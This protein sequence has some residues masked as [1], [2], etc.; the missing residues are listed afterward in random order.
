MLSEHFLFPLVLSFS[1]VGIV[2]RV[3]CA[4]ARHSESVFLLVPTCSLVEEHILSASRSTFGLRK[5]L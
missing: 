4:R 1:L 3:A 5:R 2:A